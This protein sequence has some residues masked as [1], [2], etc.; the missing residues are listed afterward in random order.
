MTQ[1]ATM[2]Q[3]MSTMQAIREFVSAMPAGE[4]FCI[5]DITNRLRDRVNRGELTLT[6]MPVNVSQDFKHADGTFER[7][8]VTYNNVRAAFMSLLIYEF[9]DLQSRPEPNGLFRLY[10][11]PVDTTGTATVAAFGSPASV[12]DTRSFAEKILDGTVTEVCRVV[13]NGKELD[14]FET[15]QDARNT[16]VAKLSKVYKNPNDV[17][18]TLIDDNKLEFVDETL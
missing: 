4:D 11:K 5:R 2:T 16:L 7:Q 18:E 17:L 12:S 14:A 6:D 8:T 10:S 1:L 13:L 9:P 15:E 3:A